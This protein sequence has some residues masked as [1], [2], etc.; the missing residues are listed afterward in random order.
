MKTSE[1]NTP[2]VIV[3][4]VTWNRVEILPKA[5]TSALAQGYP[6][7]QVTIVDNGSKDGTDRLAAHFPTVLWNQWEENRGHMAARNYF[8][9]MECISGQSG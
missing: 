3:G 7:L 4:I 2:F 8:M 6:N 1:G 9:A 5:I